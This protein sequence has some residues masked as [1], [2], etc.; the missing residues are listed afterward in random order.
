MQVAR[1]MAET[2]IT[3][4]CIGCEPAVTQWKPFFAA[5]VSCVSGIKITSYHTPH[6]A[7]IT[8]G[9][10][11]PLDNASTLRDVIVG[12]AREEI[13]L[14]NLMS[15]V[16]G[17]AKEVAG[18]S[19]EEQAARVWSKMR[20]SNVKCRQMKMNGAELA[21]PSADAISLSKAANLAEARKA[22]KPEIHAHAPAPRMA[23]MRCAAPMASAAPPVSSAYHVSEA[24]DIS[25]AQVSRM[26]MKS[27]ARSSEAW[28]S[29]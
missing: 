20:E 18:L 8:G 17:M 12:G 14:E 27:K 25:I 22:F 24:E 9:Q 15:D 11:C 6:Q 13:A 16:S 21:A 5:L 23:S 7:H 4:Y 1:Q 29:K 3:L 28:S 19:E 2:G 26:I 10:Y